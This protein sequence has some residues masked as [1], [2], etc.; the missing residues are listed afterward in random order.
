MSHLIMLVNITLQTPSLGKLFLNCYIN[1]QIIKIDIY[2]LQEQH[3]CV[4]PHMCMHACAR[5]HTLIFLIFL[6][7][8]DRRNTCYRNCC[9]IP[10]QDLCS[11]RVP[12]PSHRTFLLIVPSSLAKINPSRST[13]Q[14]FSS[15]ICYSRPTK[16]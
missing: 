10:K 6:H 3:V 1:I 12:S 16:V 15:T 11:C 4:C 9:F 5:A 8:L 13:Q 7:L 14:R 2:L